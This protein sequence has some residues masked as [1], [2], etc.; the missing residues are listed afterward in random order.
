[1]KNNVKIEHV[2]PFLIC[3]RINTSGIAIGWEI[4]PVSYK[5][6]KYVIEIKIETG[7]IDFDTL[8]FHCIGSIYEYGED[9]QFLR[10]H[11]RNRV[12]KKNITYLKIDEGVLFLPNTDIEALKKHLPQ[13]AKSMFVLWENDAEQ[14]DVLNQKSLECEWDG[15]IDDVTDDKS[16]LSETSSYVDWLENMLTMV[17]RNYKALI[18]ASCEDILQT[19]PLPRQDETRRAIRLIAENAR[20]THDDIGKQS[21]EHFTYVLIEKQLHKINI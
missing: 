5:G 21:M 13:I 9:K 6:K 17:C 18:D 11:K 14:Q 2:V 3:G 15:I 20:S 4:Y 8:N 16:H 10:K 1:M 7:N 19:V 12:F